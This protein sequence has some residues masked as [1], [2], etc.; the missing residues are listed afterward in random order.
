M[1]KITKGR[2]AELPGLLP[3]NSYFKREITTAH[4]LVYAHGHVI[5]CF[6]GSVRIHELI[7]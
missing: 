2:P 7:R 1:L 3:M 6:T 4:I 5:E